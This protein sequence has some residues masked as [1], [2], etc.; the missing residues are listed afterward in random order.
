M[1]DSR[2]SSGAC[3]A[4]GAG[5]SHLGAAV[6]FYNRPQQGRPQPPAE[7]HAAWLLLLCGQAMAVS[8]LW[9]LGS[10]ATAARAL[11]AQPQ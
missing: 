2:R 9:G 11:A 8:A 7:V 5:W 10:Q 4:P 1:E 6:L 3:V